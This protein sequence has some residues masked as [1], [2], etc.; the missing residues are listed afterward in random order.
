MGDTLDF[1]D[2]EITFLV[3]ED[4][5]NYREIHDWMIGI[6]F[7]KNNEQFTDIYEDA[8]PNPEHRHNLQSQ[9]KEKV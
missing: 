5:S 2:L 6:G 3:N 1:E 4:L 7:P 8:S 9:L